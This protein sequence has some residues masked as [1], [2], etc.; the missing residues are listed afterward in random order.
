MGET[1]KSAIF[2]KSEKTDSQ[3]HQ[4]IPEVA[5]DFFLPLLFF[6]L[7]SCCSLWQHL[8]KKETIF[9]EMDQIKLYVEFYTQ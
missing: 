9:I 7:Q 4:G 2:I 5:E 3:T 6:S 1:D 8:L